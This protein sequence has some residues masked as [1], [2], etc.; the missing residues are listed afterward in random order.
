MLTA[1]IVMGCVTLL[2]LLTTAISIYSAYIANKANS[3]IANQFLPLIIDNSDK[4]E[5]FKDGEHIATTLQ[6]PNSE[7]F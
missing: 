2:S 4:I 6:F 5:H 3:E 1:M 7:G